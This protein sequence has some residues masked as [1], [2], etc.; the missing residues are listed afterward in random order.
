MIL[1]INSER[2]AINITHGLCKGTVTGAGTAYSCN[3]MD[4]TTVLHTVEGTSVAE[5]V[6]A[7]NAWIE[8]FLAAVKADGGG[9]VI[10]DIDD[11]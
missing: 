5:T 11:L 4:G 2:D 7:A 9:T 8:A 10:I 6:S 1:F 3:I